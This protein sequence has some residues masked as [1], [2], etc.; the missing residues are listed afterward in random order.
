MLKDITGVDQVGG[1]LC[2]C[3]GGE[4]RAGKVRKGRRLRAKN[5]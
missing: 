2:V 4:S 5:C 1:F 3:E